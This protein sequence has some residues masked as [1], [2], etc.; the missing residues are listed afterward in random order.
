[1]QFRRRL[2]R[3]GGAE[4]ALSVHAIEIAQCMRPKDRPTAGLF[5]VGGETAIACDD[6]RVNKALPLAL[7]VTDG[8]SVTDVRQP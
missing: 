4:S 5:G 3:V 7:R 6:Q 2:V 1:M 8:R